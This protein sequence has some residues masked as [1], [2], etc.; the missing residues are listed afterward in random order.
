MKIIK[1]RNIK[2]IFATPMYVKPSKFVPGRS[3]KKIDQEINCPSNL[4][5]NKLNKS[6]LKIP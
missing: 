3:F 2:I 6:I 4:G 1:A 5:S